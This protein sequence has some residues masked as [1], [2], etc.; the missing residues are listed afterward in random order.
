MIIKTITCHDVYNV[1]ASLQAYALS[2]YLSKLGHQ[3]EIINYKPYY[4]KHY[5]LW[6]V[7]NPK[8]DKPVVGLLYN[9]AKLPGRLKERF[10][11]RKK[12][13]DSFTKEYLPVTKTTYQNNDELKQANLDADIIF[14]GS[15]QIWNTIFQNGKDP[16]FYLDFA[17]A[18]SVC[19]SYAASFATEDIDENYK[20]KI[21]EWLRNLN[22][23]SVRET[24]GVTILNNLGITTAQQVV[25]PVFLLSKTEWEAL[26]KDNIPTE[27]YLLIYD[28][29]ENIEMNAK[30]VELAQSNGWSIYSMF[31]NSIC[32]KCFFDD[33]PLKFVE[34]VKNA[35]MVISNSFHAVAFSIIF[36]RQFVLYERKEKINTRMRDLL[37][38]LGI[39]MNGENIDY[40]EV[41]AL[42]Q[43]QISSSK[44]YIDKV[45]DSV[46]KI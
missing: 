31:P 46:R 43:S 19:A 38:G 44:K 32:D 8:Y 28:F 5:Q 23:V 30:A 13:F 26:L 21:S 36:E 25:D 41:D 4:L 11:Q 2:A 39:S 16:A 35:E 9:L 15:D 7:K 37:K 40:K 20:E 10:S 3:V 6:G 34:L 17:P 29:D 45:I 1:G 42:L 12:A 33:G 24:S 18:D 14:A 22:H 27:K